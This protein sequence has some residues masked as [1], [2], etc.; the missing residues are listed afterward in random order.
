MKTVLTTLAAIFVA[1]AASASTVIY[2]EAV[3]GDLSNNFGSI[4]T[5]GT[6]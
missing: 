1:G 3:S 5:L 4:S 2:D 6:I